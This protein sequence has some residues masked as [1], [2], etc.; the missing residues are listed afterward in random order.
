MKKRALWSVILLLCV[1]VQALAQNAR[2]A[3]WIE[4]IHY[5]ARRA[6]IAHP[7]LYLYLPEHAFQQ[8]MQRLIEEVPA[9][10]DS[11]VVLGLWELLAGLRDGH[12]NFVF[13]KSDPELMNRYFHSFPFTAYPFSDGLYIIAATTAHADCVGKRVLS[14]GGVPAEEAMRRVSKII[15]ADNAQGVA[16]M[17]PFTLNIA[18]IL[19]YYDINASNTE[20]SLALMNARGEK[21]IKAFTSRPIM[22]QTQALFRGFIP[23]KSD[24]RLITMNQESS[25]PLPL[26]LSR[27]EE[28]YWFTYLEAQK[29]YYLQINQC[30][31]MQKEGFA[32]FVA[33]LFADFDRN[34][35]ER[36]IVDVRRNDGGNHIERPLLKA[37]LAR[38]ALDRP[39]NLFLFISRVTYSA[40]Q[41]LVNRLVRD[42]EVTLVGEPTGS[43]CNFWGS[44][45]S[46]SPPHHQGL[47]FRVS[48]AF[49]QDG[50]P[51]DFSRETRPDLMARLSSHHYRNNIDPAMEKVFALESQRALR[52]QYLNALKAA[53]EDQ[54][55]SGFKA[56]YA[57]L[58]NEMAMHEIDAERLLMTD[59]DRW[60]IRHREDDA[61]YVAYLRFVESEFPENDE[62]AF[63]LGG[64]L[65]SSGDRAAAGAYY[66]KCL[67]L[68]PAHRLAR[69][70]YETMRLD[71]SLH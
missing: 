14:I 26:W 67:T 11:E 21:E 50:E 53:F 4:D 23:A 6:E 62:V 32:A 16:N 48:S 56:A 19:S 29:C 49:F 1:T 39:E 38:P 2:D 22:T 65:M 25:N 7:N 42:T 3:R 18:E 58:K 45:K 46:F 20:L 30:H 28:N 35:A 41:H 10:S 5:I 34:G 33:R 13:F 43:R 31:D 8:R 60:I 17:M 37:I 52:S 15:S 68:N 64:W 66:R 27:P 71:A 55:L 9:R 57:Q 40:S 54:G 24:D 70:K 12:S 59:V 69:M 63:W 47:V 36:L 51:Q 61:A 44:P